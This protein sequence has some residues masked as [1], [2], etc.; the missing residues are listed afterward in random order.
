[1]EIQLNEIY[2]EMDYMY[3]KIDKNHFGNNKVIQDIKTG[4]KVTLPTTS[5][6]A[7]PKDTGIV[8]ILGKNSEEGYYGAFDV[9]T[10]SK[11]K[12]QL[13]YKVLF[14]PYFEVILLKCFEDP[15]NPCMYVRQFMQAKQK[16]I[17]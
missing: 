10:K 16:K 14:K 1:M 2:L 8:V 5:L 11:E 3:S 15:N 17:C 9:I 12:S 13:S 4:K 6:Y 7:I